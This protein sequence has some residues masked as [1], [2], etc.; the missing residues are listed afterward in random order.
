MEI[1]GVYRHTYFS[2]EVTQHTMH[3]LALPDKL[4]CNNLVNL[5]SLNDTCAPGVDSACTTR[6]SDNKL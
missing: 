2:A 1:L 4:G 3:I 5:E 6:L